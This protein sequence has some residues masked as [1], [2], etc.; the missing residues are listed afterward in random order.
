MSKNILL[1]ISIAALLG[2]CSQPS[3]PA[4]T[5]VKPEPPNPSSSAAIGRIRAT[6]AQGESAVEVKPLRDPGVD[7]LIKQAHDAESQGNVAA[8]LEKTNRALAIAKDAPDILQ[9]Q[10]ELYIEQGDWKQADALAQ[11]SREHGPKVG[12]LCTRTQRTLIETKYA[13]GDTAA[14]QQA[15]VQ[16]SSCKVPAPARL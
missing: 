3:P 16:L 6:D 5:A 9:Y 8:A 4:K 14:M 12:S 2:A 11:K 13:L 15:Q 1:T 10:A 7:G